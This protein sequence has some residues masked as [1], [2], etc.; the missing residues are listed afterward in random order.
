MGP[1]PFKRGGVVARLSPDETNGGK[2][3]VPDPAGDAT[4]RRERVLRAR[5][6]RLREGGDPGALEAAERDERAA[7]PGRVR[8]PRHRPLERLPRPE[9]LPRVRGGPVLLHR[10]RRRARGVLVVA[11]QPDG[12]RVPA[13]RLEPDLD[14]EPRGDDPEP[15]EPPQRERE[16]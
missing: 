16:P 7:P 12:L 9:R 14:R 5:G 11:Q 8:R 13:G 1:R 3:Y 2:R 4:D 6:S 15:P 10:V